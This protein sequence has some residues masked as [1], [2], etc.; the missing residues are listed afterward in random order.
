MAEVLHSH[1]AGF[2]LGICAA[3]LV[4]RLQ[5]AVVILVIVLV[6]SLNQQVGVV[7]AKAKKLLGLQLCTN[8]KLNNVFGRNHRVRKNP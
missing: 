6:G 8:L 4:L 5:D 1:R 7:K 3:I 2:P